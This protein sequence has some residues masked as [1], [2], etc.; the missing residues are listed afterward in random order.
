MEISAE[1]NALRR[2]TQLPPPNAIEQGLGAVWVTGTAGGRAVLFRLGS[3]RDGRAASIELGAPDAMIPD[4]LAVGEGA[5]WVLLGAGL[6]RVEPN[7]TSRPRRV[8]ATSR[9]D[10]LGGVAA[11]AGA[12]WVIDA[13]RGTLSR[14]DPVTGSVTRVVPVG[15]S[16]NGVEVSGDAV[17]VASA[18][19]PQLL[20]V[21]PTGDRVLDTVPLRAP[22]S[23]LAVGAGSVWVAV[24]DRDA[25]AKVDARSSRVEWIAVGSRPTGISVT[26]DAAWVANSGANTVSRI[27]SR[28]GEVEATVRVP[29]RPYRIAADADG[30]WVTSLGEPAPHP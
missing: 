14:L 7:L 9:G 3:E 10:V 13:G 28:T 1:A 27:D 16:P 5:V 4:D 26:E 25:V 18:V 22:G 20:K 8:L 6:F 11:G 23:A 21:S 15:P 19:S 24:A 17:W 30:V 29:E 12:V 2:T